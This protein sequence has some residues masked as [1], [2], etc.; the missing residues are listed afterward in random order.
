MSRL[1]DPVAFMNET[2]PENA[3]RRDPRPAGEALG[4]VMKIDYKTGT[5]K[6]GDRTGEAWHRFDVQ[7]EVTD[8]EYLA[9]REHGTGPKEVFTYGLMYDAEPSGAPKVG[10]NVNVNLGRFREACDANGK[11]WNACIGK[12]LRIQVIQKPHPDGLTNSDGSP[13]ILD[14]VKA[15]TKA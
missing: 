15:V 9:T 11:P 13:V 6:K 7:I 14:E 10:P 12:F 3:T 4:Q 8:P 1:F 5:I 2:A